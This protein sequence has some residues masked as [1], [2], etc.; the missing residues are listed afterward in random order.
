MTAKGDLSKVRPKPGW[1][2]VTGISRVGLLSAGWVSLGSAAVL[3]FATGPLGN[4]SIAAALADPLSM[5]AKRSPGERTKAEL[6]Q[7][8]LA[9]RPASPFER[10]L[11]GTRERPGGFN[12]G[13]QPAPSFTAPFEPENAP[14]MGL[15]IAI[16]EQA[17]GLAVIGPGPIGGTG[18]VTYPIGGGGIGGGGGG[19]PTVPPGTNNPPTPPIAA[20]PEPATWLTML[21]GFLAIGGLMRQSGIAASVWAGRNG[22]A[23]A[24]AFSRC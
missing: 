5:F 1:L 9:A 4:V 16:P 6:R 13:T 24:V 3:V 7:T 22:R 23:R 12:G 20:V 15:P 18:I 19:T 11:S 21:I 8:K 10:V 14:V 2:G 17:P